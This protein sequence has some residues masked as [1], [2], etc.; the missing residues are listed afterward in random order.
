MQEAFRLELLGEKIREQLGREATQEELAEAAGMVSP[1]C[2][3]VSW[4][5]RPSERAANVS[6]NRFLQSLNSLV[7][8]LTKGREARDA[9]VQH[10]LRLVASVARKYAGNNVPFHDLMQEGSVG[11]LKGLAKFDIQRGYKF[12]TYCHWWIRQVGILARVS[13]L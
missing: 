1:R 4:S 6:L 7:V 5:V 13:K 12:S 8:R 10:N 2:G 3:V 11:L 9:M